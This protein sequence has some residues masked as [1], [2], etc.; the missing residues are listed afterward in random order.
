M[1]SR[2]LIILV[3][4]LAVGA[5]TGWLSINFLFLF[6]RL[7]FSM[8]IIAAPSIIHPMTDQSVI[9]PVPEL[10]EV[11]ALVIGVLGTV[12]DYAFMPLIC[13]LIEQRKP[14]I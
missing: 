1:V 12:A 5:T 8:G 4:N 13:R 6:V 7:A 2:F 3:K 10:V 9:K 14:K 11:F